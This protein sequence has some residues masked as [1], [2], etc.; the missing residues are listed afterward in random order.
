M[1]R[2]W[3]MFVI[4]IIAGCNQT[5]NSDVLPTLAHPDAIGTAI[6]LTENAPP[7]GFDTVSFPS[8]DDNLKDLSGWRYEMFFSFEGVF[9]RTPRETGASTQANVSYNQVSSAQRVQATID[10]DLEDTS[11]P[12]L[13]EGVRHGLDTFLVRDERCTSNTPESELLADLSAGSILGGVQEAV[14]AVRPEQ[15]NGED[16]WLYNFLVE[17]MILPNVSLS[18]SGRILSMIGELWVA[19]EHNVVMRYNVTL[20]VENATIFDGSLPVSGT[21]S[22][23]YNLFDIGVVPNISVPNGC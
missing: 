4:L 21:I 12:I 2:L 15:V 3:V 19:P 5:A 13:F 6:V 23:Q 18:E 1:R 22:M 20:E 9:A 8:I 7:S 14:S 16:V 17:D 11:D 10:V